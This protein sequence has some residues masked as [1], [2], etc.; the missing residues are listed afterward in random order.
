MEDLFRQFPFLVQISQHRIV[1]LYKKVYKLVLEFPNYPTTKNCH[2]AVYFANSPISLN[3][4]Q[5]SFIDVN[6]YVHSLL[7]KLESEKYSENTSII[8]S[9]VSVVLAPLAI[10]MLALQRK[11]DCVL[12]FDKYLRQIEF[13][14]F[15]R[16]GNHMLALNRVGVDLF[17]VCQHTLPELAVSEALKRHN[18]MHRHLET[19]LYTLAQMEEFY[20]NLATIDELCYVILP[21]TIDTKTVFRVFKYDLKVFLKIT[22]H[23]LSPMEVDISFLGPTKQVA[24]L[25]EMYS[26]KQKDWDP[27]CSVYTNLLRIFNIIAFPMRP[28]GMPSPESEDNCGICMNYHVAGHVWTIPIISCDNEQ[29]PLVFHIHCLKE[30]FS[31]QRESKCFFSISIGNCPYC[32]HKISSSFDVILDSVV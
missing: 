3:I 12:V 19:F 15:E 31:T 24:K 25:K 21:A 17:K 27:K 1:G 7:T 13:K 2:V 6:S 10:D 14:N 16:N 5:S 23:P 11:Y 29:C 18:S 28:A 26:E 9:N 8:K 32:K 30:W 20:S 4:D 22:L